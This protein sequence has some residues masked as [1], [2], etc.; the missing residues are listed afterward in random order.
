MRLEYLDDL[1]NDQRPVLLTYGPSPSDAETLQVAAK[2][3]AADEHQAGLQIEKLAG[4]EGIDDCSLLAEM[5][6]TNLGVVHIDPSERA[7][8]CVLDPAGWHR[9]AGLLEPF[10][11]ARPT[12]NPNGFQYLN[13]FG[14]IDWIISGSS[15]W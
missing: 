9:V 6:S 5:D 4:F 15:S 13:E 10:V 12:L 1:D 2:Q 3:L 8:R 11:A 14:P 7:F